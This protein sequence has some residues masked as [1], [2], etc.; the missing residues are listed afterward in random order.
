MSDQTIEHATETLPGD[1]SGVPESF[2]IDA[3][4][5]PRVFDPAAVSHA[6]LV[7]RLLRVERALL[8]VA[9]LPSID[10]AAE[11]AETINGD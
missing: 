8:R 4:E 2:P 10:I 11:V 1:Q 7:M 3:S 6:E 9:S 5:E